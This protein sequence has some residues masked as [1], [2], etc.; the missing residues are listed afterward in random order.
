MSEQKKETK[1]AEKQNMS[2]VKLDKRLLNLGKREI[3]RRLTESNQTAH[4]WIN[5]CIMIASELYLRCPSHKVFSDGT[6][7]E[8]T[9]DMILKEA[10]KKVKDIDFEIIR[11]M[12][13]VEGKNAEDIDRLEVVEEIVK[14]DMIA[15]FQMLRYRM[16]L[17]KLEDPDIHACDYCQ[18]EVQECP[19]TIADQLYGKDTPGGKEKTDNIV[20]CNKFIPDPEKMKNKPVSTTPAD[21]GE[22]ES[23]EDVKEDN[24]H[25]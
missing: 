17:D 1:E 16:G 23:K 2:K 4:N 8:S 21:K 9:A 6:F 7:A 10:A 12:S 11:Y 3:A 5:A 18:L 19:A 14:T 24:S 22:S 20:M 25:E 15:E 13:T